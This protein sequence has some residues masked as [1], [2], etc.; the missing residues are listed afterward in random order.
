MTAAGSRGVLDESAVLDV[1][2]R[3]VGR[4]LELDPAT[5]TM[6]SAFVADLGADSLALVEVVEL[7]EEELAPRVAAG[8]RIDDDDLESLETVGQAVRYAMERL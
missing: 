5:V 3:A 2:Q 8:F 4:V 1:V 7:V 6:D